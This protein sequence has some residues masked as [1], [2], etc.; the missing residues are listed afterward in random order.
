MFIFP[1]FHIYTGMKDNETYTYGTW[2]LQKGDNL[3]QFVYQIQDH[4]T[5]IVWL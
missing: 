4:R 3:A 1:P 2:F 5:Y